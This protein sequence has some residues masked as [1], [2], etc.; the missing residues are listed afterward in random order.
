MFLSTAFLFGFISSFHCAGMCGPIAISLSNVSNR[1][2]FVSGK[3]LYNAGRI[4]TYI[5]LGTLFGLFGKGL[6]L[7]GVQQAL[8]VG[9]GVAL[10]I[11]A[12]LAF[13]PDTLFQKIPA[14]RKFQSFI[15]RQFGKHLKSASLPSMFAIGL[16]NGLLPCGVVYIALAGS[17]TTGSAAGGMAYMAVFGLGTLPMMLFISLA[18]KMVSFQFRNV[19]RKA[20]PAVMVLFA[21]LLILRGLN[22]NIPYISPALQNDI[23][24]TKKC[25]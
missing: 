13:N 3:L 16:L 5:F 21:V 23:T 9:L 2:Q 4:T 24:M 18:G 6:A 19:L 12:L 8:S 14:L 1:F 20:A 22:L 17:L 25:H 10:L 7:A 11:M 15:I